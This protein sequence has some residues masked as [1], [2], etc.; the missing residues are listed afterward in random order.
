MQDHTPRADLLL[1]T[2]HFMK[3]GFVHMEVAR[4]L[5]HLISSDL[6]SHP[7]LPRYKVLPLIRS[8]CKVDTSIK[9][10]HSHLSHARD[11]CPTRCESSRSGERLLLCFRF[12]PALYVVSGRESMIP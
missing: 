4:H 10:L 12:R 6:S 11:Q 7:S 3:V 9:Y 8:V 2:V 5:H 1:K